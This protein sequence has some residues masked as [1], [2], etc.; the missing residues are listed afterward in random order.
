M[1]AF[2]EEKR[3]DSKAKIDFSILDRVDELLVQ[4]PDPVSGS[5]RLLLQYLQAPPM[6]K[7]LPDFFRHPGRKSPRR[8]AIVHVENDFGHGRSARGRGD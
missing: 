2:T 4:G 1:R 8:T 6:G 3:R 7:R 5:V